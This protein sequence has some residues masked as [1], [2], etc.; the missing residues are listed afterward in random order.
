MNIG[1]A[2]NW[3]LIEADFQR[4]YQINLISEY[5]T[6]SWRR[7]LVLLRGLGPNSVLAISMMSNRQKKEAEIDEFDND[8]DAERWL[9][10]QLGVK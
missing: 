4:E 9:L 1:I 3:D 2:E 7:F 5:E 6:M 8:E 10:N